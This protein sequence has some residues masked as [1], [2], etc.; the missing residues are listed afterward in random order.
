MNQ[1]SI[2]TIRGE[3]KMKVVYFLVAILALASSLV[4]AHDPSPLQDFCVAT[5]E[6]DGGKYKQFSQFVLRKH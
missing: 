1:N 2:L 5:K 6:R 4:S 3:K